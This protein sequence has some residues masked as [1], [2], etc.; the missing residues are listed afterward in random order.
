MSTATRSA[1]WTLDYP[2]LGTGPLPV[3]PYVSQDHFEL[4][5]DRVFRRSWLC[6]GKRTDEIPRPGDFL[7]QTVEMLGASILVVRGKDGALRAF[8][9]VC[10]HRGNKLTRAAFGSCRAALVCGYHGWVYGFDGRLASVTE[11]DMFFDLRKDGLD[12]TPVALDTWAGFI[13]VHLD[14]EPKETLREHLGELPALY[15]GYP[16]D[17]LSVS[18]SY[19]AELSCGWNVLRDSQLE[20]YHLKYLHKRTVPG[21][22]V[23]RA[24]PSRHTLD[25]KLFRRHAVGSWYGARS[26]DDTGPVGRLAARIGQTLGSAATALSD[27]NRW[28]VGLNPT[29]A[30]DWFFDVCYVFPNFHIIFVGLHAFATHTMWPLTRNRTRWNARG[31]FPPVKTL[32]E[33]FSREFTKCGIRDLWLEDGSMLEG[34]QI[35]LESGAIRE[36]QIQ[37]QE[38]MIRHAEAVVHEMI[39]DGAR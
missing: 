36:I 11:E 2:R 16:F 12:L 3:E 22:M 9:N 29:R 33:R 10:K 21:S 25:F 27:P 32:P 24:D 13:F 17:A 31:Y 26:G 23:N 35:G 8:H 18:F 14:P 37:D 39:A 4:V 28:P 38:I 34:T 15:A 30:A 20:G 7:V 1:R 5:R 6:T 19:T